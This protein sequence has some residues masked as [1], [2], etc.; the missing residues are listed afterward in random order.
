MTTRLT[1]RGVSRILGGTAATELLDPLPRLLPLFTALAV[2][3]S[4]LPALG[5]PRLDLRAYPPAAAGTV[6]WVIQL[7]GVLRPSP[8]PSLSPDPAD[9]RVELLV[10]REQTV[11]CNLR[12]LQG[13][14]QAESVPGWGYSLYR[15]LGGGNAIT[16]RMACPAG[17]AQERRFIS[18]SG[19]ATLVPY[20]ASLPIVVDAPRGLQV[21]WRLWKAERQQQQARQ[22]P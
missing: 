2:L 19:P 17:T 5:V 6:R 15:V 10:G 7:P 3:P 16:T 18:L 14:I 4:S 12:Q 8:D 13:E 20:N 21:R 9:W 11:D 22:Q 1:A